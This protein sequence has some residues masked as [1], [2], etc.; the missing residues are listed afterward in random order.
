[1]NFLLEL[2]KSRGASLRFFF[3]EN[4]HVVWDSLEILLLAAVLYSV[5]MVARGTRAM[6]I[7]IGLAALLFAYLLASL[8]DFLTLSWLLNTFFFWSPVI[9]AV[10]FADNLRFALIRM[11]R[12]LQLGGL[13]EGQKRQMLVEVVRACQGLSEKNI[14]ALIVIEREDSLTDYVDSGHRIDA[15]PSEELL[16]TLF[17]TDSPLHDGAVL[18]QHG[19]LT[20]AGVILPLTL[21]TD[22]PHHAGT[23]HRAAVGLSS[24]CDAAVLVVSEER[25]VVSTVMKGN[26]ITGLDVNDL[27]ESLRT[28]LERNLQGESESVEGVTPSETPAQ[29]LGSR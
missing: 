18:I 15:H 27:F 5:M 16:A 2:I 24:L 12:I 8:F 19:R 9:L 13:T 4:F 17:N 6:P 10:L 7:L 3:A 11:G 29:A 28:Y 25:G 26:M 1:M 22:L 20:R 14:G 21:R 23:R